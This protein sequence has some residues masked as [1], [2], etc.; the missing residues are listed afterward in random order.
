MPGCRNLA[1]CGTVEEPCNATDAFRKKKKEGKYLKND[2]ITEM[3]T[4][5]SKQTNYR[6]LYYSILFLV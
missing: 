2:T 1:P 4:E 3:I 5:I 6:N